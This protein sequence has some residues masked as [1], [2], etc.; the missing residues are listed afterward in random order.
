MLGLAVA[1]SGCAELRA[2]HVARKGNEFFR[3]GNYVAAINAYE[4][5]AQLFSNFP[6]TA[7]NHG[8]ACRQLME[9]GGG[10]SPDSQKATD[11]ALTQFKRL[12]EIAPEDERGAQLYEQT[13]F[14]ANRYEELERMYLADF[15]KNPKKMFAVNALIQVYERWDKWDK[16]FEWQQK[17]AELAPNDPDAHYSIGVLIFS[18]LLEKGG[19]GH[20]ASYDP[21]PNALNPAVPPELLQNLKAGEVPPLFSVTD[22]VG[23]KRAELA[24]IGLKHLD[25]ALELRTDYAEAMIYK[26]LLLRQKALA[27]LGAPDTWQAL[28]EE[29]NEW[30][31]KSAAATAHPAPTHDGDNPAGAPGETAEGKE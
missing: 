8:L 15:E 3:E 26:G 7:L 24:D 12:Q 21:R 17:R 27:H 20:A 30:A 28:I 1:L 14:D 16:Q 11:C 2:R 19:R 22:I 9:I 29:A 6:T 4:E 31:K 23:N 13:L 25:R 5:S 18:R 10:D